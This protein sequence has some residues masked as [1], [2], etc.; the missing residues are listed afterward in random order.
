MEGGTVAGNVPE[1]SAE[2]WDWFEGTFGVSRADY[3]PAPPA[4]AAVRAYAAYDRPIQQGGG[5]QEASGKKPLVL[6]GP[7]Y[8][9][10]DD[11]TTYG[12]AAIKKT[13]AGRSNPHL[14]RLA[15]RGTFEWLPDGNAPPKGTLVPI[16]IDGLHEDDL[17][18]PD[19]DEEPEGEIGSIPYQNA[20]NPQPIDPV[21]AA[22]E[23]AS[24]TPEQTDRGNGMAEQ[25]AVLGAVLKSTAATADDLDTCHD[26][27]LEQWQKKQE[28]DAASKRPTPEDLAKVFDPLTQLPGSSF[29]DAAPDELR[30]KLQRAAALRDALKQGVEDGES[31]LMANAADY[32]ADD[33]RGRVAGYARLSP[34]FIANKKL[35]FGKASNLPDFDPRRAALRSVQLDVEQFNIGRDSL[36]YTSGQDKN[37]IAGPELH[38]AVLFVKEAENEVVVAF[39]QTQF[40]RYDIPF[41]GSTVANAA[42]M[43]RL[44]SSYFENAKLLARSL[45]QKLPGVSIRFVGASFGGGLALVAATEAGAPATIFNASPVPM[46]SIT[47]GKE[48]NIDK[49][50][51]KSVYGDPV[52]RLLPHFVATANLIKRKA[53]FPPFGV[54]LPGDEPVQV[55]TDTLPGP[56]F[57]HMIDA[58]GAAAEGQ[59]KALDMQLSAALK[60]MEGLCPAHAP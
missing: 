19:L 59:R 58:H 20:A 55:E 44:R 13:L 49:V 46:A 51:A 24:L 40:G 11:P 30:D 50:R 16:Y 47:K 48:G 14:E 4:P 8:N 21:Q 25:G 56:G 38:R 31:I 5:Q 39:Q 32:G 7:P 2:H 27:L 35:D 9:G 41:T 37:R 3:G 15:E 57:L 33:E 17:R 54:P 1:I 42:E 23:V 60:E 43:L 34:T 29:L 12:R 52:S 36:L 10:T 18:L 28:V 22:D 26:M 53:I 6:T 45:R